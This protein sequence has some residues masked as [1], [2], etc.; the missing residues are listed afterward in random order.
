MDAFY[1]SIE[2]RDRPQLRGRPVVVG[3]DP[4]GRG[5]V[6]AASYEARR[7]G[8]KSAMPIG[9]AARLCPQAAFLPVDMEKYCRV[10]AQ[11]MAIL[12][13]FSPVVEVV[14]VDEAFV[15][16]TGTERLFGSGVEAVRHIRVRIRE[17]IG[18]TASAGLAANTFVAKVASD[19]GKPDGLIVVEPGR[20]AAFLAP[21]GVERIW[22]VG[23]VTAGALAA[24]G[25]MTIGQLQRLPREHL[26]RRFGRHGEYLHDLAFG[27]DDRALAPLV[28]AKS[29]GAEATFAVDCQ[30]RATLLD[31]LRAQAE[32]VARELRSER[33]AAA[34][35]T[36][37]LRF[38]DFRT[39]TRRHTGDPTQ[40]G[41]EIFRRAVA[42]LERERLV[43]P[44]RL[45]GVSAGG[46]GPEAAGQLPLLDPGIV[47]RERVARA[48]DALAARFGDEAV[49][50]ATLLGRRRSRRRRPEL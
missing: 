26:A 15:D 37:K 2:Q 39:L 41:L 1:A 45:I 44:V 14:S 35:V 7:F 8:V 24:L 30:D 29:I 34:R 17:E 42:L 5:V 18:L 27:R 28:P 36:L 22:G 16:L 47:R 21:L 9:R 25:V 19:L 23:R 33:L 11:I 46:L 48:V 38:A 43:Q 10:S 12:G 20:E 32:R 3:A 4:R 6:S 40:D 49:V 31:T 13:D 50:P